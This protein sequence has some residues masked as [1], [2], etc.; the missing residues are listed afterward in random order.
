MISGTSMLE[1][2]WLEAHSEA[3]HSRLNTIEDPRSDMSKAAGMFDVAL[4]DI[5]H[6]SLTTKVEANLDD[7]YDSQRTKLVR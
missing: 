3:L 4:G 6:S 2:L 1:S 5:G 7:A